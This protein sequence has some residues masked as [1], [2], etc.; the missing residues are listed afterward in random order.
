[1]K[2]IN[3]FKMK[4]SFCFKKISRKMDVEDGFDGYLIDADEKT[5]RSIVDS[6]KDKKCL[7]GVF[8]RDDFFNRRVIETLKVNYL[9][10]PEA[11]F[12]KDSVKQRDSGINHVVVKE[13][14]RKGIDFVIDFNYIQGLTDDE[15]A[16]VLARLIQNIVICRKADCD[17]KIASFAKT[18]KGLL[19]RKQAEFFLAGLGMSSQQIK[20]AIVF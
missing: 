14:K 17:I 8:G 10:M 6:L 13:A 7:V 5:A 9:V 15:Q 3:F 1:M 16:R 12:K 2:D 20:K 19:S 18:K 4:D 11:G